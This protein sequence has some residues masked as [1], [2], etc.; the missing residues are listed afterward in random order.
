M[1]SESSA[2]ACVTF[3]S[4]AKVQNPTCSFYLFWSTLMNYIPKTIAFSKAEF[5][6]NSHWPDA[7]CETWKNRQNAFYFF[8]LV[9][10]KI[11]LSL[12]MITTQHSDDLLP[13]TARPPPPPFSLTF[14]CKE[15]DNTLF[16]LLF[17]LLVY[18]DFSYTFIYPEE[19]KY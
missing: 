3:N 10:V 12:I 4:A 16:F 8:L 1:N 11:S 14:T 9:V 13:L 6:K 19:E 2:L 5:Y 18:I 17:I 15:K 7:T